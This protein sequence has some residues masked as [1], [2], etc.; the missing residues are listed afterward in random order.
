MKLWHL[1]AAIGVVALPLIWSQGLE[2]IAGGVVGVTYDFWRDA[3]EGNAAGR[4]LAF[5]QTFLATACFLFIWF[6]GRNLGIGIWWRIGYIAGAIFI[7]GSSFIPFF[8][9]HRQRILDARN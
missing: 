6:E 3:L 1:Y 8:L 9:A 2:Y 4:F 5:D 7:A